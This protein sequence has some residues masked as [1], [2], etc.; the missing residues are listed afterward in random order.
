MP[1]KRVSRRSKGGSHVAR[2]E[3]LPSLGGRVSRR[4]AGGSPFARR[5]GLP[6]LEG[7]V[8]LRSKGVSLDSAGADL[9]RAGICLNCDFKNDLFDLYDCLTGVEYSF[10]IFNS[11]V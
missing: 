6:S 8:S 7:R 5:E 9:L 1:V 4:S 3:G 10:S 2:R 11:P